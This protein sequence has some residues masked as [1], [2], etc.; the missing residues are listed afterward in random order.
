MFSISLFLMSCCVSSLVSVFQHKLVK[1][2]DPTPDWLDSLRFTQPKQRGS[3]SLCPLSLFL[4]W[5]CSSV[6]WFGMMIS[7][8]RNADNR[9]MLP[10][11]AASQITRNK[12][13][14]TD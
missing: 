5:L 14:V 9:S 7:Q 3:F 4:L 2:R 12:A 11:V 10:G 13:F 8:G 1:R 6:G